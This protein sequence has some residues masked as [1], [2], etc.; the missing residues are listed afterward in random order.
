MAVTSALKEKE[1][2][3]GLQGL[4][5]SSSSPKR[6]SSP[7]TPEAQAN[8]TTMA[9][10]SP[11]D[12]VWQLSQQL[13]MAQEATRAAEDALFSERLR[14]RDLEHAITTEVK[15]RE[16]AEARVV[17]VKSFQEAT[18]KDKDDGLS[19]FESALATER[20]LR[21]KAEA[22]TETMRQEAEVKIEEMQRKT[23]RQITEVREQ[24]Q[25]SVDDAL[26]AQR[27][28]NQ[29]SEH[30]VSELQETLQL[31]H[32][33]R[34]QAEQQLDTVQ[35]LMSSVILNVTE[36]EQQSRSEL[37]LR[38]RDAVESNTAANAE[39]LADV[40]TRIEAA[41][42]RATQA[43]KRVKL[44]MESRKRLGE[45]AQQTSEALSKTVSALASASAELT[46][47]RV[48]QMDRCSAVF[49]QGAAHDR[50]E[51]HAMLA[52]NNLNFELG[53]V[54][55]ENPLLMSEEDL[56]DE[57]WDAYSWRYKRDSD[58][59]SEGLELRQV[60][61]QTSLPHEE[62]AWK[63]IANQL[64]LENDAATSSKAHMEQKLL[65]ATSD[66]DVT[67]QEC[68]RK[69]QQIEKVSRQ[70][71]DA[72]CSLNVAEENEKKLRKEVDHGKLQIQNLTEQL[73]EE[74]HRV[75]M[76]AEDNFELQELLRDATDAKDVA[77]RD[78]VA[79]DEQ[80]QLYKSNPAAA[81]MDTKIADA[82][83]KATAPLREELAAK[84]T[85]LI[86]VNARLVEMETS[87][88][89]LQKRHAVELRAAAE[90]ESHR[91]AS[92][93]LE[94]KLK[95]ADK[96]TATAEERAADAESNLER[97]IKQ[98]QDMQEQ[99]AETAKHLYDLHA[100]EAEAQHAATKQEEKAAMAAKIMVDEANCQASYVVREA[101]REKAEAVAQTE[102]ITVILH[103]AEEHI[104]ELTGRLHDK[105]QQLSVAQKKCVSIEQA[106]EATVADAQREKE[107]LTAKWQQ[108]LFATKQ[109]A[110]LA[111]GLAIED[112]ESKSSA[113]LKVE[114]SLRA[115]AEHEIQALQKR[116]VELEHDFS[117]L[118]QRT[119]DDLDRYK[120]ARDDELRRAA[121]EAERRTQVHV[122]AQNHAMVSVK[123]ACDRE[124]ANHQ[125]ILDSEIEARR[126]AEARA[127]A[128][129]ES[130]VA[131]EQQATQLTTK[132]QQAEGKHAALQ[133]ELAQAAADTGRYRKQLADAEASAQ[134]AAAMV[135]QEAATAKASLVTQLQTAET[136]INE[137]EAKIADLLQAKIQVE[138][139]LKRSES[140]RKRAEQQLLIAE[141][142][143]CDVQN[144]Q[145]GHLG[146]MRQPL[147]QSGTTPVS[148][149][150]QVAG[151][152]TLAE[153]SIEDV[154][155]R[156]SSTYSPL[157][158][159]LSSPARSRLDERR[160]R[161]Q[162]R[163]GRIPLT[164][165]EQIK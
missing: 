160:Q 36:M 136:K 149:T 104:R 63:V 72:S 38:V 73:L 87:L 26:S 5:L 101:E 131:H 100:A 140:K 20:T 155:N 84:T 35:K 154:T 135:A 112:A 102:A 151:C 2:S 54:F 78:V 79:K 150:D 152:E 28:L 122:E 114:T 165:G 53:Y 103:Q 115:A 66:K 10:T 123:D 77:L 51:M 106:R 67:E 47:L 76:H 25:S 91:N 139:K 132:L 157:E 93:D 156:E 110:M 65:R 83:A 81:E 45:K 80:L 117:A 108:M 71:E 143:L 129:T 109:E 12:A 118:K 120:D 97:V 94:E 43:E 27:N 55:Q 58:D 161:Q 134:R 130:K 11:D 40:Q 37:E 133:S 17:E 68:H 85:Q 9:R 3:D 142:Q 90:D 60:G 56:M 21:E 8:S 159:A 48:Q 22:S 44:E 34:V 148:R 59:E 125:K 141:D 19:M 128:E 61:C 7:L 113:A 153:R 42:K 99:H 163:K 107:K 147:P 127:L 6:F 46:T 62:Q 57:F 49:T 82:E 69:E 98:L 16:S 64:Q 52:S 105:E 137:A 126:V 96:A 88:K 162:F 15:A 144:A 146:S 121:V 23:Q 29:H 119:K 24:L 70:L 74:Q 31:E 14:V 41:E 18:Q 124:C 39:L 158:L 116:I 50:E 32:N 95:L 138:A 75:Q 33:G 4:R 13:L 111:I 145:G 1:A 89:D 92:A 30:S 86:E 164:T